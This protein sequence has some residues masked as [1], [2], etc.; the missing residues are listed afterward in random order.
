MVA[1]FPL[2]DKVTIERRVVGRDPQYGTEV[3]AWEVV[4][5]NIWANVQDVLPSRAEKV[6]NGLRYG[7]QAARLR[8]RKG[9]V[10]EPDMRVILHGRGNRPMKI[11]AGPA[12][13]DDRIN[14][15]FMLEG[16][17]NGR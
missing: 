9:R 2:N 17:S 7:T 15:E 12:M 11:V 6:E 3:E 1:P 10:I 5:G 4:A 14:V 8:I 16:F 13:L